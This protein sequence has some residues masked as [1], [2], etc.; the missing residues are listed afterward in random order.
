MLVRTDLLAGAITDGFSLS[1]TVTVCVVLDVTV[2]TSV[3]VHLIVVTPLGYAAFRASPSLRTPE[4]VTPGASSVAVAVPT[5]TFAAQSAVPVL[6]EMSAG[7]V[8]TG[9]LLVAVTENFTPSLASVYF[10][11][12]RPATNSASLPVRF[13]MPCV[14]T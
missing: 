7:A 8:I 12:T 4:I 3:A 5:L 9:A 13:S 11:A 10:A 2:S 1:L 6:T 14:S